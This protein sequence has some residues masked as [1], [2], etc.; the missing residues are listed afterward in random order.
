[1]KTQ[2]PKIEIFQQLVRSNIMAQGSASLAA[3]RWHGILLAIILLTV[4]SARASTNNLLIN[5][6]FNGGSSGWSTF[7]YGGGW[8]S[9]EIPGPLAGTT[10]TTW[11]T[12]WPG[13]AGTNAAGTGPLYDGTLQ[14]TCGA[15]G[16]GGGFAWQTI[17][18][19]PGVQY[20]LTVQA[21]AQNWWLPTGEI[22]LWFL[23]ASS[24]IITSNFVETCYTLHGSQN[25][26]L[27]DFYD[28]GVPYQNWTNV[29]TAPVGT[30][31]LKVELCNPVGTGSAWFDNAYLTAP[32]DPPTFSKLYPDGT[33]LLQSTNKLAFTVSSAAPINGSGI[34][35]TL[36][37]ADISGGLV[38]T[39]SG[40]TNVTV[41]YSGL[42]PNQVYTAAIVVTDT[43]NFTSLKN[44]TFDTFAPSFSWEAEDYDYGSGQFTNNPILSGTPVSGSY[45]GV[46]GTEGIDFHDKGASGP[47][48][49]RSADPMST[50]ISGDIARQNF[51][52]AGVSDYMVGYFD[53]NG[54]AANN[55]VGLGGYQPQEWINY[56]RNF[57][58]G[59]YN[60]CARVASGN[61]PT[62]TV[63][64]SKVI[65][66]QGTPTQTTSDLGVFSFP[67]LGWGSY[68]YIPLTDRFGNP[69]AVALSGTNT[70]K[71]LAGS[72]ANLNFF[73]LLPVDANT[74]AIT[75]VY[76]D[77]STLIQGTN[78][79]VFTV[80]SVG[81]SI[82]QSN[83]LVTLN[84]V[85]V[86][87]SLTFAGS[88]SSW[89]AS[90]PL[91]LNVT[92][93]TAV[94]SVTNDIGYGHSTTVYF[95][96][97]NPAS[98]DIEAED[99]DFDPSL[100]PVP[101]GSGLRFI[102]NPVIT[103]N[104]TA[105]SYFDQQAGLSVDAYWGD[106]VTVQTDP[107]RYRQSDFL[108]TDLCGDN[109]TRG[110]LAAQLTNAWAFGY[111]IAY[112]ATNSWMNYTHA[113]PTNTFNV[114]GRLASATNIQVQLDQVVG[115]V[116]NYI[117]TF[118][119]PS[120]RG[121]GAYDWIPL[122]NTNNG[123]LAAVTLGGVAT[124][125]A[126]S[127]VAGP[128]ANSYLLV[129]VVT[130][131]LPLQWNFSAG[132]LTLN[133]AN[134]AFHLQVQTNAISGGLKSNWSNY[135]GGGSSPV[136]IPVDKL[137]GSVFFRLSN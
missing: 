108:S 53:G 87:S 129:P 41:S 67:A 22:R 125:R 86:S 13:G 15:A 31:F 102:D 52:D 96:T 114:Y 126:T 137:S 83:V 133:W 18:A 128:N 10:A 124:L 109:P 112:W 11:P 62:A 33:R 58:A 34:S 49:Y 81:H 70:L 78:K 63:H 76:P 91:A 123:Q 3:L 71:I 26:G 131:P 65:S 24:A 48:N 121:W 54:F 82:A 59:T 5:A 30:K 79:L 119:I 118:A 64:V 14:L 32:I 25:G 117:G 7:T 106:V 122:V 136:T 116:P 80:S 46:T 120:G 127:L 68:N 73:F 17:A 111:N 101:T 134:A 28:V 4:C 12:G 69:V 98:Y 93:Y 84:G 8:A 135:P 113:Y 56:T 105:N 19:A 104:A 90:A 37:G 29:A 2:T 61:G 100:S 92:N 99:Y 45:F 55:N 103:S 57:P 20:T 110:L 107:F 72:G 66:G 6:D 75:G 35:V 60:V 85:N 50:D 43:V 23:D 89:N 44:I 132:V 74:P 27:G 1:M 47:R 97:F 40:T 9:F 95:D 36:N 39:G 77:G 115:G 21:G 38:I 88:A 42:Q 51:V 16:S 130:V 94:I